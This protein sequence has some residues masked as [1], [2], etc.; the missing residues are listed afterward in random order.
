MSPTPIHMR[1]VDA[2]WRR[3][4]ENPNG[5]PEYF[6]ATCRC[7][8]RV[9][10][11]GVGLPQGV[12]AAHRS[13]AGTVPVL[14]VWCLP[15]DDAHGKADETA[16]DDI[17]PQLRADTDQA[18]RLVTQRTPADV[19]ART[20]DD[21]DADPAVTRPL[22]ELTERD[23]RDL[24]L[25]SDDPAP[26]GYPAYAP[27]GS[28][29]PL[30]GRA[31][32]LAYTPGLI[33]ASD[34]PSAPRHA[35]RGRG[36]RTAL[37][38]LLLGVGIALLVGLIAAAV[39]AATLLITADSASATCRKEKPCTTPTSVATPTPT[40]SPEPSTTAEPT[41]TPTPSTSPS[42]SSAPVA[43]PG[44][45]STPT[46]T[47]HPTSQP[48]AAPS[49]TPTAPA[50][51]SPAATPTAP[52]SAPSLPTAPTAPTP[53]PERA[54]VSVAPGTGHAALAAT[55]PTGVELWWI[56][57]AALALGVNAVLFVRDERRRR[58]GSR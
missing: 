22:A 16:V 50:T 42:P 43:T 17:S 19:A 45:S 27:A 29:A 57:A 26:R 11:L 37:G 10:R 54:E 38:A 34:L 49:S 36:P 58:G 14:E 18:L 41:P 35:R 20:S 46:P 48:S 7:G 47:S 23:L 53:Q 2:V 56:A 28:N 1:V 31:A 13:L 15:C 51:P 40:P 21:V 4:A 9:S 3:A 32:P 33:R 24:A 52:S 8:A 55:G 30:P 25:L 39:F 44:P 5:D 6:T 12:V